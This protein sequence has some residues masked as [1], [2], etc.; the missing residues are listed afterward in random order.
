MR[1]GGDCDEHETDFTCRYLGIG[2]LGL[3][4][5]YAMFMAKPRKVVEKEMGSGRT[6]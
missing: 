1:V 6:P 4:G 3:G 5:F 2:A